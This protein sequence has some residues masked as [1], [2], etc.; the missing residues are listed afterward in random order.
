MQHKAS[1]RCV[2]PTLN[3]GSSACNNSHEA[4]GNIQPTSNC[5]LQLN[6]PLLL[7]MLLWLV[8]FLLLP[9]LL[10]LLLTRLLHAVIDK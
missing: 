6:R 8:L 3:D 2:L 5:K 4:K 1:A 7:L 10:L 9:R